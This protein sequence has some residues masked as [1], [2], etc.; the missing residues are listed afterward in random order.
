MLLS[1]LLSFHNYESTV[2]VK[3]QSFSVPTTR[4]CCY[5]ALCQQGMACSLS[6]THQSPE[7]PI[8]CSNDGCSTWSVVHEG[9]FSETALI[10]ILTHTI[11]LYHNI[12]HTPTNTQKH[13]Q[14]GLCGNYIVATLHSDILTFR[15]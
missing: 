10:I 2:K 4:R 8:L 1:H 7:G 9:Q 3:Q 15:Y 5:R 6:H 11:L 13:I 14:L 12:I